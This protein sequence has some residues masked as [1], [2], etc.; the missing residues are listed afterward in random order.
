MRLPDLNQAFNIG[1]EKLAGKLSNDSGKSLDERDEEVPPL[2][3][4]PSDSPNN[5]GWTMQAYSEPNKD[6]VEGYDKKVR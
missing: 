3:H 4:V 1:L 5:L 6:S 2:C